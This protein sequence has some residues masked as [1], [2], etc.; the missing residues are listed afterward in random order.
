MPQVYITA[1]ERYIRSFLPFGRFNVEHRALYGELV[2]PRL[3][4][5]LVREYGVEDAHNLLEYVVEHI[6]RRR[7]KARDSL[8]RYSLGCYAAWLR[9]VIARIGFE[10]RDSILDS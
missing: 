8:N 9:E 7:R 1:A 3:I 4:D 2:T 10:N 5:T 6:E